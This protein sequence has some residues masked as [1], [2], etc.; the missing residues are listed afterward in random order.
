MIKKIIYGIIK[1]LLSTEFLLGLAREKLGDEFVNK[2]VELVETAEEHFIAY[3]E[4][5]G[6]DKKRYVVRKINEYLESIPNI[7]S[8]LGIL[9]KEWI[10]D[11]LIELVV[12]HLKSQKII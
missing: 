7:P 10:I 6:A 12:A 2:I 8:W 4:K 5:K 1:S 9:N 11:K 3:T